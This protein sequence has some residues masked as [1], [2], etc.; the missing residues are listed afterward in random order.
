MVSADVVVAGMRR[1]TCCVFAL[2]KL[3]AAGVGAAAL[4]A[5][6]GATTYVLQHD[7]PSPAPVLADSDEDAEVMQIINPLNSRALD[8]A[9]PRV[10]LRKSNGPAHQ[11][12]SI[13]SNGKVMGKTTP[14][15]EV[16][17]TAYGTTPSRLRMAGDAPW[18]QQRVDYLV[19]LL[20]GQK[21]ALQEVIRQKLGLTA[22]RETRSEDVYVLTMRSGDFPH[23]NLLLQVQQ[24]VLGR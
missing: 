10:F 12:G 3:K 22:H 6:G 8:K 24:K 14:L 2:S 23:L 19:S 11:T 21:E 1:E 16:L 9:P 20:A 7:N 4:L 13:V 5:I 15:R 18:P 17:A